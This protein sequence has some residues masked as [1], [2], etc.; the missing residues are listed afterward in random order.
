MRTFFCLVCVLLAVSF[1]SSSLA[2]DTTI[3]YQGQLQQ[4]GE[5]FTGTANLEFRLFNELSGGSQ[6]GTTQTRDDWPVADG[7]FQVELNFGAAAFGEQ[8]RYLEVRVDGN[9]LNPRQAVRPSPT[10]LFALSSGDSFWQQASNGILYDEGNVNVVGQLRIT[11]PSGNA[12]VAWSPLGGVVGEAT[13]TSGNVTGVFGYSVSPAGRGVWGRNVSDTGGAGVSGTASGVGG[14]GVFGS[15]MATTGLSNGVTGQTSS[16]SGRG[17]W[18]RALATSGPNIGV[19]GT[20]QSPDGNAGW[21]EGP[22]G[23][24]NFFQRRVGIGTQFP[25]AMLDVVPDGSENVIRATHQNGHRGILGDVNGGVYGRRGGTGSTPQGWL[26]ENNSGVRGFAGTGTWAGL[27]EGNVNVTGSLSK[28]GGSFKIDHPLD[29]EN[30][31]LFHSFVESPDMMNVYNG[32]VVTD[33]TGYAIVELPDYFQALNTDFRYQ[34]TVIGTFAQAIVA[35]EIED[36][37]FVIA[38]DQ[39]DV[40]VSWQVTGIRDDAW[41]RANRIE[42]EVPKPEQERGQFLHPEAFGVEVRGRED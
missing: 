15:A 1:G 17:V 6:V 27:F 32:N 31:Y 23:S 28:G 16:I 14:T 8:V 25:V 18:G 19:R 29:P 2:Q 24:T 26:G 9:A 20:T 35:E 22:A 3:T 40:K 13:D 33:H 37:V 7:L 10:A 21:F 38:T 30:Q 34:L 39:P 42:V 11:R 41:A 12:I 36:N 4:A 5:P